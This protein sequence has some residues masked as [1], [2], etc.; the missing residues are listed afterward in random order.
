M[1]VTGFRQPDLE[2]NSKAEKESTVDN[3]Q[4]DQS[5]PA[6]GTIAALLDRGGYGNCEG[7]F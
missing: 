7:K 5:R 2:I 3:T 4:E 1:P 6:K